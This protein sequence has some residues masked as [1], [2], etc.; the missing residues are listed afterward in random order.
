[1]KYYSATNIN[2]ALDFPTL[3][4]ALRVGFT[5]DYII[6]PRMHLNYDNLEDHNQNTLLLM[7]AVRCG[8]VAGVKIVN[9]A[10]AN[11]KRN[12]SSIQG[13]YY[14]LDAIS[15]CPKALMDA[16][17]LTNWR[18][19]AV[20]ALAADYLASKSA[21][22]LL[23]VGTGALAPFIIDAHSATR[24]IRHLMIYGR[25]RAKAKTIAN[26]KTSQFKK[27]TIV[28]SLEEA[29]PQAD[30]ISVATLSSTPLIKGSWLRSGQHIDLIGSYK[31]DM[32]E[33]DDK[34]FTKS[35]I[36]VD[37]LE[38]APKESG[39]LVIPL[40]KG[41][42]SISDIQGDL[43]QLCQGKVKG[44]MTE[45]EITVFKSVGHA[46]EDLVAAQLILAKDTDG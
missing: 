30:I 31:P 29:V 28:E 44:R 4:E 43:F 38:M 8:E 26:Q 22:S 16:K 12:L 42:I 10:P 27:V 20:S 40:N 21:S 9:V 19:A 2:N 7:P 37:N 25:D 32:R 13:I 33:A 3:I 24:S 1:M 23:M 34:V 14:L 41:V 17:I 6:P 36:Y 39:D 35:R 18:T 5:K 15:G 45:D 46:L 11:D